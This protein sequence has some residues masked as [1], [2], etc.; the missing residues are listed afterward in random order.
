MAV[1][2][3]S[4]FILHSSFLNAQG[5]QKGK[6]SYYARKFSGRRTASGERLHHDSLTCAHLKYP[7]GTLL[8]V[9]NVLN[10]KQVVVRVN[11]RGPYRKGRIIDLS[12]GAAK[13]IG[14]MAQGIV[15]VTVEKVSGTNIPYKP[16]EDTLPQFEFELADIDPTGIIP[17]WQQEVKIDQ[18]KVKNSMKKTATKSEQEVT[19]ALPL[20][21]G[22]PSSATSPHDQPETQPHE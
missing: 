19:T 4:L 2:N 17:V 3:S 22:T 5:V 15:P 13:A 12:W 9:T 11:D 1:A 16:E 10:G 8:K 21:S 14:M 20:P 6:A 7:F 18:N